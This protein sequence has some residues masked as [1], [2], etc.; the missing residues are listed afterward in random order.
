MLLF[1]C[2]ELNNV[3]FNQKPDTLFAVYLQVGISFTTYYLG[4]SSAHKCQEDYITFPTY[5]IHLLFR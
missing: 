2:S 1:K 3:K 4:H 5:I